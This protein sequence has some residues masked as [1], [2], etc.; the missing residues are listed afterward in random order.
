MPRV[1]R[2]GYGGAGGAAGLGI[3]VQ[4]SSAGRCC[5]PI[6]SCTCATNCLAGIA[7]VSMLLVPA[8]LMAR[9]AGVQLVAGAPLPARPFLLACN[10]VF[11][12]MGTS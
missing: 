8:T 9:P 7:A 11:Q 3:A 2:G 12:Q 1:G 4:T 6:P 5:W 10:E